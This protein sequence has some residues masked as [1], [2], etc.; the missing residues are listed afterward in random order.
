MRPPLSRNDLKT[1]MHLSAEDRSAF[2]RW[3]RA[4]AVFG[5]IL[6]MALISM[7]VMGWLQDSSSAQTSASHPNQ[8]LATGAR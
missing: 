8:V 6:T 5:L 3:V 1:Y 7:S 2:D 4:N